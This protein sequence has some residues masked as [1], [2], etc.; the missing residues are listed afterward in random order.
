[1]QHL[2]FFWIFLGGYLGNA[3]EGGSPWEQEFKLGLS[4]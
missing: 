4:I 2:D 3:R 1:M